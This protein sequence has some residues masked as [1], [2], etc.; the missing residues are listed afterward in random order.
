MKSQSLIEREVLVL[1]LNARRV[2]KNN[3]HGAAFLLPWAYMDPTV[4]RRLWEGPSW[5]YEKNGRKATATIPLTVTLHTG[6]LQY[7]DVEDTRRGI[8]MRVGIKQA[9]A[10]AEG[11]VLRLFDPKFIDDNI[12]EYHNRR[13]GYFLLVKQ[14]NKDLSPF[15]AAVLD[16]L[17]T[18]TRT[19]GQLTAR[20]PHDEDLVRA[21]VMNLWRQGRVD[22]PAET[23]L[24]GLSWAVRRR[25][26]A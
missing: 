1:D 9:H 11:V 8:P 10:A 3:L 4:S 6:E 17:G 13:T 25:R 5:S 26:H 21:A 2:F 22:V 12:V 19:V 7:W 20:L 18:K 24:F 15:E 23:Q 16:E 14:A